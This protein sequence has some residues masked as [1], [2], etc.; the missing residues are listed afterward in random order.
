MLGN[1][2]S[3]HSININQLK[4]HKGSKLHREYWWQLRD[5]LY[6]VIGLYGGVNGT[7]CYRGTTGLLVVQV[8]GYSTTHRPKTSGISS[9]ELMNCVL[10][11]FVS[12][13]S[14][15]KTKCTLLEGVEYRRHGQCIGT[16]M[17]SSLTTNAFRMGNS[18]LSFAMKFCTC[19]STC[20]PGRELLLLSE[21]Y[22]PNFAESHSTC[23][24]IVWCLITVYRQFWC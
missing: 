12:L 18:N 1:E 21:F 16:C 4:V 24:Y 6:R 14:S 11:C 22:N 2:C 8:T 15:S 13:W 9:C 19:S 17:F 10:Y 7:A 5:D 23:T 3:I 20:I